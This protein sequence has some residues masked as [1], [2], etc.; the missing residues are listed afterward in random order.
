M[1]K[2][3][4]HPDLSDDYAHEVDAARTNKPTRIGKLA[5]KIVTQAGETRPLVFPLIGERNRP[6]YDSERKLVGITEHAP[7]FVAAINLIHEIA[8]C[9]DDIVPD[10]LWVRA[11]GI[12]G[13]KL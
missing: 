11:R 10:D 2:T 8:E 4:A 5:K 3:S 1:P 7:M 13:V 12:V 9:D 6:I